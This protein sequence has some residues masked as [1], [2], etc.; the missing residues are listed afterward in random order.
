MFR[1]IGQ[2]PR[3]LGD[4]HDGIMPLSLLS[5]QGDRIRGM[6][7]SLAFYP[8]LF[9]RA[10]YINISFAQTWQSGALRGVVE[11]RMHHILEGARMDMC[12]VSRTATS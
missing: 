3:H 8:V 6:G 5:A 4:E 12:A 1:H 11:T 10:P 7:V 2:M 9:G